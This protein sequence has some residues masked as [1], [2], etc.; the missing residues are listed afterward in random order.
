MRETTTVCSKPQLGR[1]LLARAFAAGVSCAW[2][3]AEGV[4]GADYGLRRVIGAWVDDYD[5][6]RPHSS[7]A[8]KT[9][10]QYVEHFTATGWRAE[11]SYSVAQRASR[12]L[13]LR[14]EA[15]QSPR[16]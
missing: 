4:Y 15:S 8:Y 7:L 1:A 16:L 14:R 9:P 10:A 3:T 12:L 2:V 11:P 13:I 6:A 5:T